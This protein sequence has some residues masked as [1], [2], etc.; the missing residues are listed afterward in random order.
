[1]IIPIDASEVILTK[2][3]E[4]IIVNFKLREL[5]RSQSD[6]DY[7]IASNYS[8]NK[9]KFYSNTSVINILYTPTLNLI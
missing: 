5:F 3:F 7:S 6:F 1:M 9:I 2:R 8:Q 4:A